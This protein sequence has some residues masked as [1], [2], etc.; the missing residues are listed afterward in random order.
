M[1]RVIEGTETRAALVA[2]GD[3]L[4]V[5]GTLLGPVDVAGTLWGTADDGMQMTVDVS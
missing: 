1:H 4:A 3:E 5:V 2:A